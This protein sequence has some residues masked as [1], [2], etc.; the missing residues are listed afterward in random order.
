VTCC[1]E[2]FDDELENLRTIF[3]FKSLGNL[4]KVDLAADNAHPG[5]ISQRQFAENILTKVTK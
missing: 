2:D 4:I 3:N 1:I 5:E